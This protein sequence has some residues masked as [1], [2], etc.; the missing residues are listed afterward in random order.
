MLSND[1]SKVSVRYPTIFWGNEYN[2]HVANHIYMIYIYQV[3]IIF[4][5]VHISCIERG[6]KDGE[7]AP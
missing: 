6:K 5:A 4:R 3:Y 2:I 7:S 1:T